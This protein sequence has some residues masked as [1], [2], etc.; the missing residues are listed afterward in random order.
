[1]LK[2]AVADQRKLVEE[3]V[4][5]GEQALAEAGHAVNASLQ[6]KL[7]ATVHAAAVSPE[8]GDLLRA[9]RLLRDYEVSDLGLFAPGAEA[10]PSPAPRARRV[11]APATD[12]KAGERRDQQRAAGRITRELERARARHQKLA[13]QLADAQRRASE[14]RRNESDTRKR[15]SEAQRQADKAAAQLDRAQ[16]GL[17]QAGAKAGEARAQID[18]LEAQMRELERSIA[19]K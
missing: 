13:D 2:D 5:L 19:A 11:A 3:V 10:P 18:E 16:A 6:T 14:A 8:P 15:A 7:R 17:E 12:S 4:A 9:G 1:M